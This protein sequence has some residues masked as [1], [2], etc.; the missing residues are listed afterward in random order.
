MLNCSMSFASWCLILYIF[1]DYFI[2]TDS[3]GDS[4]IDLSLKRHKLGT[5][6][7]LA[8]KLRKFNGT[9]SL[10]LNKQSHELSFPMA[11]SRATV[12]IARLTP[13]AEDAIDKSE[14]SVDTTSLSQPSISS[15]SSQSQLSV[16]KSECHSEPHEIHNNTPKEQLQ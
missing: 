3:D 15:L 2:G 13:P 10:R 7:S 5:K 4:G 9:S 16:S 11:S 1:C 14:D 8:P 12:E 6:N